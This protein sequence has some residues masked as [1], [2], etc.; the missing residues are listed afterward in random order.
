MKNPHIGPVTFVPIQSPIPSI[1][2][3]RPFF[4]P[5]SRKPPYSENTVDGLA[6]P[7]R[8]LKNPHIGPVTFVSIQSPIPSIAPRR[9]LFRPSRRFLPTLT[10]TDSSPSR[11]NML[12]TPDT[13]GSVITVF[14]QSDIPVI[15]DPIPA[16]RPA[17]RSLPTLTKTDS[18]PS[19]PNMLFTPDTNGSTIFVFIQVPIVARPSIMPFSIPSM[20]YPPRGIISVEGDSMP[21]A[22]LK[23]VINGSKIF[24]FIHSPTLAKASLIPWKPPSMMFLPTPFSVSHNSPP[25]SIRAVNAAPISSPTVA[26]IP[27]K[28]T[29]STHSSKA[30]NIFP[31]SSFQSISSIAPANAPYRPVIQFDR[32]SVTVLQS[33]SLKNPPIASITA[34]PRAF[35]SVFSMKP[36]K[37]LNSPSIVSATLAPPSV[38]LMPFTAVDRAVP[39]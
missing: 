30:A 6:I 1:A 18:S 33:N 39:I 27:L 9:P 4:R 17:I 16:F 14:I 3:R 28:S 8:L 20:M 37:A 36:F 22:V 24:V 11:P 23:P 38:Q 32:N 35:Q 29:P 34:A 19:R 25:T 10:K 2:A 31:G 5:A 21:N 26:A 15:T 7:N 12:F 13:N